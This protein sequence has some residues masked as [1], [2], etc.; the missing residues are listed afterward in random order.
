MPRAPVTVSGHFDEWIQ[1]R[2]ARG[3]PV[4][5]ITLVCP[6]L[7]ARAPRVGLRLPALFDAARLKAFAAA[8][9]LGVP[10][11]PTLD[12]DMPLGAGAG[13]STACLVASARSLGHSGPPETEIVGGLWGAS[14][15]TVSADEDFPDISGLAEIWPGA[16]SALK[17]A[18][19]RDVRHF[20]TGGSA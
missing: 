6:A 19:L 11:W 2:L 16:G 14:E 17:E 20:R 18:G 3:G 10:D 9:G 5:L 12:C 1:G 13:A 8:L 7:S 15:P 4:V